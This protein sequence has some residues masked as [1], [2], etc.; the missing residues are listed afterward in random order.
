MSQ[1]WYYNYFVARIIYRFDA[2]GNL[3]QSNAPLVSPEGRVHIIQD[4][5]G[6]TWH[7]CNGKHYS[8]KSAFRRATREN[9]CVE[10]G[11][12]EI[13]Q[14]PQEEVGVTEDL[15]RAWDELSSK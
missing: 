10:L 9:G 7:P 2:D 8:S 5:M 6:E 13:K 3:R 1:D 11:N 14:T 12:E 15:C 4:S